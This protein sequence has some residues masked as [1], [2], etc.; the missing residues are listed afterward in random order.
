MAKKSSSVKKAIKPVKKKATG[1]EKKKV[2]KN[3]S[4]TTV[5]PADSIARMR[6]LAW[7]GQHAQ[8]IDL[9]T[10]ALSASKIKPAEQVDLLDLRAESYIAHGKL[11]LAAKDANA[12]MK[13]ANAEKKTAFKAQALNRKALVQMRTGELQAAVKSASIAVGVKRTSP[14]LRATSLFHLSEAQFRAGQNEA[15]V[16][17]AQ[18]AIPLFQIAGDNSGAGRA[19]WSLANAYSKLSRADDS[20][21]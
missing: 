4:T 1:A 6:E 16:E 19:Y 13:L 11:D 20:R 17:T 14:T 8:A 9:S 7:T 5:H 2:T 12:M 15:A 3:L 18:K 21:P 10:Q